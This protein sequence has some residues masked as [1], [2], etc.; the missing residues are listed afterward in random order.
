MGRQI[1]ML[2]GQSVKRCMERREY[3]AGRGGRGGGR[4]GGCVPFRAFLR[5]IPGGGQT[6][7]CKSDDEKGALGLKDGSEKLANW[8]AYGNRK[9]LIDSPI[10]PSQSNHGYEGWCVGDFT[11][12]TKT[13]GIG[14]ATGSY[15]TKNC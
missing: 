12:D 2:A 7:Q 8:L 14:C 15:E 6:R 4:G 13:G 11:T 5:E 3:S 9:T 1:E 10:H